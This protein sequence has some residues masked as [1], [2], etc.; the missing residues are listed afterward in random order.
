M[1]S[2]NKIK[3]LEF[4][5]TVAMLAIIG[6]HCQLFTTGSY[7]AGLEPFQPADAF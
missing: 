3:S 5:R 6:L 4:G 7:L 1:S 2:I